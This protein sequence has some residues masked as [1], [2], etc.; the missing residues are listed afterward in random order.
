MKKGKL[1]LGLIGLMLVFG[2]V[3]SGCDNGY[4]DDWAG[5]SDDPKAEFKLPSVTEPSGPGGPGAALAAF[6][7]MVKEAYD[8]AIG[9]DPT[10][11][12]WD[13]LLTGYGA[14]GLTEKNPYNWTPA[15]WEEVYA[16]ATS[17]LG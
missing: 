8:A 14:S 12:A 15:I 13:A 5:G 4:T 9:V 7:T 17:I 6:K 10:G 11:A 16:A 3:L 2:L 1:M